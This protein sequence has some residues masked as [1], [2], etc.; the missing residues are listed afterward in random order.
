MTDAIESIQQFLQAFQRKF[1]LAMNAVDGGQSFVI[2]S[3]Q[4]PA[5]HPLQGYGVSCVLE[6]GAVFERGGANF[7]YVQ[8]D[9][10]PPA[11]TAARSELTGA[12]FSALGV[13]I[14]M[15]PVNPY[16]PT[17]HANVRYFEATAP[18]GEKVW[19]FGGGFD[20]TPFY[21]FTEDCVSWHTAAKEACETLSAEAYVQFKKNADDYFYLKNRAEQR[22]IGGIFYD[23]LDAPDFEQCFAFM[24]SVAEHYLQAY[25]EIILRRKDHAYG[26][27]E[28]EFQLLRRGRYVEF[29]LLYDRGTLF[30]L[31]S[32]GRTESIL[33]S[34]PPQVSWQYDRTYPAG[35]PEAQLTDYFLKP[36]DWICKS[37]N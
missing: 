3:W 8:A 27:Q 26:Q 10:L 4:R 7:S 35:T 6:Q 29:N 16:A 36:R 28:R 2:D 37:R 1:C 12:A 13:S 15:H 25:S 21:G 18:R 20:L 19:W 31:Q 14:V 5:D 33:M 22:G 9:Q 24:Q 17:S 32:G 30:G 11:A 34:L 23:D